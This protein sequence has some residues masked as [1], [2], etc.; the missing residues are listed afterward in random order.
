MSGSTLAAVITPIVALPFL[1]L[2]L[3]LVFYA[4]RHPQHGTHASEPGR[5]L[6]APREPA[7]AAAPPQPRGSLPDTGTAAARH[8]APQGADVYGRAS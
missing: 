5:A 7:R 1:A 2:W 8:P 6:P 4:D 3:S